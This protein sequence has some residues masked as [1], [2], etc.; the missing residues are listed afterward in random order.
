MSSHSN[1][2]FW[3]YFRL[4]E[5]D[6]D[7]CFQYVAPTAEH[8]AVY[9]DR[10]S[11]VILLACSEIENALGA[12]AHAARCEPFPRGIG[13]F[14]GCVLGRF[15]AF[16]SMKV[17]LPRFS[18]TIE[19]WKGWTA[20][21]PPDWWTSGYNKIKHDRLGHPGAPSLHRA[22]SSVGGLLVVLL[23][24]YT[25]MHGEQCMMPSDLAPTVFVPVDEHS[26]GGESGVFWSWRLPK[27]DA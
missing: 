3:N 13:A 12:F 9:S 11:Q 8:Y 22:I 16:C 17:E 2:P 26:F 23:H 14:Q 24:Y 19:P 4:L 5:R 18:L 27:R 7:A 1:L 15:P 25:L 6:L 10:F 21:A 20:D